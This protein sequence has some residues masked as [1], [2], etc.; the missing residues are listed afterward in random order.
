MAQV[1]LDNLDELTPAQLD[2]ITT[3]ETFRSA[4][5]DLL[6][7]DISVPE[8]Q[9]AIAEILNE[10]IDIPYVPEAFE[11]SIVRMGMKV[12]GNMLHGLLKGGSE[13]ASTA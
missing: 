1:A 4:T 13:A 5:L 12:V 6:E 7:G 3:D 10:K 9:D 8:W 11:D 2:P